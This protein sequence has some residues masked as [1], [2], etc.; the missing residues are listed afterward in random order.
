LTVDEVAQVFKVPKATVYGWNYR[1]TG[2]QSI[3][4]GRFRR[5]R[6]RDVEAWISANEIDSQVDEENVRS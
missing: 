6:R 5:Y 4:V 1:R 3:R 2:P